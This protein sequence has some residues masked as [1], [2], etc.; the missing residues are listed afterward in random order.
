MDSKS[1]ETL[2]KEFVDTQKKYEQI[3]ERHRLLIT[4]QSEN[5]MV[6]KELEQLESD[7]VIFKLVGNVMVKQSLEDSKANVSKRLE[8]IKS[9]LQSISKVSQDLQKTLIE[10]SSKIEKIQ[11]KAS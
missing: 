3:S 7:A 9:E 5:D 10:K 11:N 8:Y 2:T 4:Q 6:F 1:L